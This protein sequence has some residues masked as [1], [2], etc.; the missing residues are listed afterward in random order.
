MK[1]TMKE[2]TM[3]FNDVT[4]LDQLSVDFE[5]GNLISL[6]GPSGCGKSTTLFLLAGLHQPTAGEIYFGSQLMNQVRPENRGIGMVFQNYALY[7]HMTVQENIEFPL[8]IK[9]AP[10][11]ERARRAMDMAELVKI[12]ELLKRKPRQ[13]SGGQQQR[14]AIARALAGSPKLLLL[15]EPLSNLDARL[16]LETR[17][18]IRRIQRE[19]GVTT[20]FVTHDQ[21]EA[22]SISDKILIMN[23]GHQQQFCPPQEMYEKP[24]NAFVAAF[25]GNPPINLMEAVCTDA[26]MPGIRLHTM[27]HAVPL[28]DVFREALPTGQ[29][30]QAGIRPEDWFVTNDTAHTAFT[31]KVIHK[32]TI[33]R[34]TLI[35]IERDGVFVRA[36]VQPQANILLGDSISLG[37]QS[38]KMKLFHI[39]TGKA[40]A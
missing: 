17:E 9:K 4:A 6:L 39:D 11:K 29:R 37:V 27:E 14:V 40:Y 1:I 7:P 31:G 5:P 36:L 25:L 32:E 34:D 2:V 21:E 16:R 8:K 18:E 38:G 20:I 15:D 35:R 19:T 30:C 13:L 24:A 22:M 10:E 23:A 28:T 33:G 26:G 3:K 12:G